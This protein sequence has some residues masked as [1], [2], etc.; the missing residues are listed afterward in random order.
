MLNETNVTIGITKLIIESNNSGIN[1]LLK[2]GIPV[3]ALITSII[4]AVLS[5]K[6][7]SENLK[8]QL[9]HQEKSLE[10][11]LQHQEK[12]LY[13]QMNQPEIM[14]NVKKLVEKI[15]S[16]YKSSICRF[17]DSKEG[18]YIPKDLKNSIKATLKEKTDDD[19]SKD[20]I[21]KLLNLV[22]EYFT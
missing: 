10:M 3:A 14:E 1:D 9:Q 6:S 13:I 5:T 22:N 11:Q 4:I 18:V 15:S 19:L 20:D 8:I 7:T 12:N 17:L 16:S 2:S 21:E